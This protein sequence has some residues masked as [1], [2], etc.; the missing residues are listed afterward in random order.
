MLYEVVRQ[1]VELGCASIDLGQTTTDTK[2]KFAAKLQN[3]YMYV[4]HSNKIIRRF[5]KNNIDKFSYN[6]VHP[7]FNVMKSE[8][9]FNENSTNKA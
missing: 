4:T 1:G 8:G 6:D 3:R 5:I 7:V 2:A 9:D